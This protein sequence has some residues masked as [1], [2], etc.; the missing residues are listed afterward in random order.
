MSESTETIVVKKYHP[1]IESIL[2]GV[3]VKSTSKT[4]ASSETS[5]RPPHRLWLYF[6]QCCWGSCQKYELGMRNY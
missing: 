4:G 5:S 3:K 2:G 6:S 1:V